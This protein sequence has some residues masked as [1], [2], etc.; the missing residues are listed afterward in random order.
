MDID[1][2]LETMRRFLVFSSHIVTKKRLLQKES[3]TNRRLNSFNIVSRTL[4][5]LDTFETDIVS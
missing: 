4:D 5:I 2:I 3:T 1:K